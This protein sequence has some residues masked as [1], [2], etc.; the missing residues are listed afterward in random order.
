M[1]I[2]P[3]YYAVIPASVRYADIPHGAKLLFA[4]LTAIG[5][6]VEYNQDYFRKALR[7]DPDEILSWLSVLQTFGA[8]TVTLE[9]NKKIIGIV[10][11]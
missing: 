7:S 6:T 9:K 8:V 10:L 3:T 11:K 5:E 4:E 2:E 1:K